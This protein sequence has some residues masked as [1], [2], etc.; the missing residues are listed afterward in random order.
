MQAVA[1]FAINIVLYLVDLYIFIMKLVKIAQFN[2]IYLVCNMMIKWRPKVQLLA[3]LD[4]SNNDITPILSY[5]YLIDPIMSGASLYRWLAK[6]NYTG[7]YVIVIFQRDKDIVMSKIN[8]D[9]DI[10][11]FTN[12]ELPDSSV[13]LRVLPGKLIVN[14]NERKLMSTCMDSDDF[15]KVRPI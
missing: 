10:E 6:F 5:F 7:N 11:M 8:L 3:A 13:G 15:E 12:Q 9:H 14:I 4:D 1:N 2:L